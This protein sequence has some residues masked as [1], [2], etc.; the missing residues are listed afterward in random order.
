ME[1]DGHDEHDKDDVDHD[2]D[3]YHSSK[4]SDPYQNGLYSLHCY[5]LLTKIKV[6]SKNVPIVL[7]IL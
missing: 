7:I 4:N 5:N 6:F 2:Q 3:L 1:D